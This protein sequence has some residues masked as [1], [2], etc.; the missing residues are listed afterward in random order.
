MNESQ[1]T[2]LS[3]KLDPDQIDIFKKVVE[4]LEDYGIKKAEQFAPEILP[5]KT[6]KGDDGPFADPKNNPYGHNGLYEVGVNKNRLATHMG[7][8]RQSLDK[9]SWFCRH[10][11]GWKGYTGPIPT[12]EE[13]NKCKEGKDEDAMLKISSI[14]FELCLLLEK[15]SDPQKWQTGEYV[16]DDQP[17]TKIDLE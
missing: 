11:A 4:E 12:E 15:M 6:D 17:A 1:P 9:L 7:R 2:T 5:P 10:Y 3:S 16:A 13:I 8:I 14:L